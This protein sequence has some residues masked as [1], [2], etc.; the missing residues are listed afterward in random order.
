ML[1]PL[2]LKLSHS[3]GGIAHLCLVAHVLHQSFGADDQLLAHGLG[4][5]T[6]LLQRRVE[7][8]NAVSQTLLQRA[9]CRGRHGVL[10]RAELAP[11][12]MEALERTKL[13]FPVCGQVIGVC[14]GFQCRHGLER[15]KQCLAGRQVVLASGLQH[16][17]MGGDRLVRCLQRRIEALPQR[18]AGRSAQTVEFLPAQTQRV[19][20]VGMR[21]QLQLW[22]KGCFGIGSGQS[23]PGQLLRLGHQRLAGEPAAPLLPALES[24]ALSMQCLM[25]SP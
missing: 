22:N 12:K 3:K 4:R 14:R 18:L 23:K 11:C 16:G 7:A 13:I 9:A 15:R 8:L 5:A 6:G 25:A 2:G 24:S 19:D 1:L 20:G 10:E 21:L 17:L